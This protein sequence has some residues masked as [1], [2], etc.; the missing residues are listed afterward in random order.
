MPISCPSIFERFFAGLSFA[1]LLASPGL[2]RAQAVAPVI[3]E[4]MIAKPGETKTNNVSSGSRSTLTI[5]TSS[6]FGT[7]TSV[8]AMNGVTTES[9]TKF[10][11]EKA[12]F[13][14]QFGNA[15]GK[16]SVDVSNVRSSSSTGQFN[17]GGFSGNSS[18][19]TAAQGSAL[20]DGLTSSA[21]VTLDPTLSSAS[22]SSSISPDLETSSGTANGTAA[23]NHTMTNSANVDISNTSFANA[24]SQAF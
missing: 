6:S 21:E 9:T 1:V 5:S 12:S 8:N 4:N 13:K 22:S 17:V 10:V 24:F 15:E 3:P 23:G 19:G 7:T 20:L 2:V 11:P 18:E 14:S 16:I